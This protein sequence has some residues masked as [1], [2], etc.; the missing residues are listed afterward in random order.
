MTPDPPDMPDVPA[1]L[2][3]LAQAVLDH[4]HHPALTVAHGRL[5]DGPP[6][7]RCTYP[8][9]G[10]L[11]YTLA[12][13]GGLLAHELHPHNGA[14]SVRLHRDTYTPGAEWTTPAGDPDQN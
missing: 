4:G 3:Q 13:D 5:H 10:A 2:H 6:W 1:D 7:I 11:F 12:P 9:R 8:D 14:I